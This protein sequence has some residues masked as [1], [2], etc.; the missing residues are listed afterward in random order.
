MPRC[1]GVQITCSMWDAPVASITSRSKP[2]AIPHAGGMIAKACKKSSSSRIG[3]A[4]DPQTF[5]HGRLKTAALKTGVR[6]F[7]KS[8]GE[9]DA[10]GIK[11]KPLGETRIVLQFGQRRLA[12]RIIHEN[13][14]AAMSKLRLDLRRNNLAEQ[15]PPAVVR[16]NCNSISAGARRERLPPGHGFAEGR[17]KINIGIAVKGLSDAQ[18][19]R[20]FEGIG[21]MSGKAQIAATR[22]GN[23]ACREGPCNPRSVSDRARPRDTIQAW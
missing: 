14:R 20:L 1:T 13:C 21:D 17:Q 7:A 18:D 16:G 12:C 15:I 23:R 6:Q 19:F 5:R 2:S 4:I 9:F 11:F 8:I 10:A 22:G 3:L